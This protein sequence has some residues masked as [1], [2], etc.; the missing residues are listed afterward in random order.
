MAYVKQ[1]FVSGQK[2]KADDMNRIEDAIVALEENAQLWGGEDAPIIKEVEQQNVI[3][4]EIIASNYQGGCYLASSGKWYVLNNWFSTNLIPLGERPS[5]I[6]IYGVTANIGAHVT[7]YSEGATEETPTENVV[8]N[9]NAAASGGFTLSSDDFDSESG[10]LHYHAT[11]DSKGESCYL[12]TIDA[13]IFGGAKYIRI[14]FDKNKIAAGTGKYE[15]LY[16]CV[17]ERYQYIEVPSEEGDSIGFHWRGKKWLALGTSLSSE[18]QGKWANPMA[19]LSGL[20]LHNRA[21]PGAKIGGHIL[22][23][24]QNAA[25]LPTADLVTVEGAVNDYASNVPLGK[26]GD[27]VPYLHTFSSP[28]WNNGGNDETGTFAGACYQ[29]FKSVREKAP[30]AVVVAIT[31]PVGQNIASTGARYNREARNGQNLSQMDYNDMIIAVAKYCGVPTIDVATLS[32]ITQET[33]AYYVD[34]LH[35]TDLGGRQFA[36]TVWAHL[37]HLPLKI[38][39]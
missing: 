36:S 2:L 6:Y 16:V 18:A 30:N 32:G 25:E 23:Y 26:V 13:G 10:Y 21:V 14:G 28:E 19:E 20:V 9:N 34:H 7:W 38:V 27:T 5:N 12:L 39:E 15:T 22:Y 33:P 35:H 29:V 1:N 3:D 24:A 37:K 4:A 17:G 31:D 11:V 8:G